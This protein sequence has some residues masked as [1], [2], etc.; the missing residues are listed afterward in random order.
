MEAAFEVGDDTAAGGEPVASI[1]A[2]DGVLRATRVEAAEV[3]LAIDELPLVGLLGFLGA[4]RGL[5]QLP[6]L[7]RGEELARP[8]AVI[9][10]SVMAGLSAVYAVASVRGLLR[11]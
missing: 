9:S 11:G 7:L 10:Q 8:A 5:R 1:R 4:A 2:R 6:A 3:P